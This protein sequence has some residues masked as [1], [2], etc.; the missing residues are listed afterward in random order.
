MSA[1][2][3]LA[4]ETATSHGSVAL[5]DGE[6]VVER[7][8]ET[9]GAGAIAAAEALL[10]REHVA[11][12]ALDA[13]AVS[14]GPGSFTGVRLGVAAA[15]GIALATGCR[16]IAVGTLEALAEAARATD[17][18]VPGAFVLPLVDARRNEVYAAL[19]RIDDPA[20]EPRLVWGPETVSPPR[21][22]E[23]LARL[24]PE[25]PRVDVGVLCGDGAAALAPFFSG[26]A[27]WDAPAALG[28]AHAGAVARVGARRLAQGT[29]VG[30][31]ELQPVYLRKSDAE[32][33]REKR[34]SPSDANLQ[35]RERDAPD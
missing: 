13:V 34:E 30:A 11:P 18:G 1:I 14:V 32:I 28:R 3:I 31:E 6:R 5:L 9:R 24:V 16:L 7:A 4:L 17:W 22:V 35:A 29:W 33:V 23:R 12:H 10:A 19:Y 25:R 21:L 15:Q 27:G 8:Y 26:G 20:G 2:R